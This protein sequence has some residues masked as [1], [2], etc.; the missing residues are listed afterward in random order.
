MPNCNFQSP[1]LSEHLRSKHGFTHKKSLEAISKYDLRKKIVKPL[2]KAKTSHHRRECPFDG[3]EKK[4]VH[5]G[6]HL[7]DVHKVVFKSDDYYTY[8][9]KAHLGNKEKQESILENKECEIH[10]ESKDEYVPSHGLKFL[11]DSSENDDDDNSSDE[12]ENDYGTECT[13]NSSNSIQHDNEENNV[14]DANAILDDDDRATVDSDGNIVSNNIL[15]CLKGYYNY[16][17]GPDRMKSKESVAENVR[18][19]RRII[20]SVGAHKNLKEL[21]ANYEHCISKDI[22]SK[23]R[24]KQILYAPI[25]LL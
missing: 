9:R 21:F 4:L 6:E 20:A 5:I 1:S 16:M 25:S 13:L 8:L 14:V 24:S 11:N 18:T 3:C 22:V 23:I 7:R 17:T 15:K 12:D 2:R 19:V 10:T